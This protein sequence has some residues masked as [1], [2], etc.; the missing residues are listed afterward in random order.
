MCV[1]SLND[2]G[3]G[4]GFECVVIA[5]GLD[6]LW[7]FAELSQLLGSLIISV[8][9]N[10]VPSICCEFDF[11]YVRTDN[12]ATFAGEAVRGALHLDGSLTEVS[13]MSRLVQ[14]SPPLVCAGLCLC[15]W[16]GCVHMCADWQGVCAVEECETKGE[17][18]LTDG[19]IVPMTQFMEE[20]CTEWEKERERER[21]GRHLM[22]L[23]C[24]VLN[25]CSP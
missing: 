14:R 6:L 24:H 8:S 22:F 12:P 23:V 20:C 18:S 9:G 5:G 13:F 4:F 19:G 1:K 21:R 3:L 15:T 2:S 10:C 11:E 16:C 25:T 7:C 17:G